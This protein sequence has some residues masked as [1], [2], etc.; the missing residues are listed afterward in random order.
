VSTT[1]PVPDQSQDQFQYVKMPDGSYGKF[2]ANASDELIHSAIQQNFPDAFKPADNRNGFQQY[3]DNAFAPQT[4]Q[5]RSTHGRAMNGVLDFGQAAGQT[6]TAPVAHPWEAI[7]SAFTPDPESAAMASAA[8][9]PGDMSAGIV[10]AL[11]GTYEDAKQNGIP[12]ALGSLGGMFVANDLGARVTGGVIKGGSNA[13]SNL[14]ERAN[15][16]TSPVIPEPLQNASQLAK[17]IRPP[18]GISH[19]LEQDLATNM[20]LVRAFARETGNPMHSQW[21]GATAARGLAQR[22][23]DN[24][25]TNFLEPNATRTVP[26]G[27]IPD[28]Q[29]ASS[30]GTATIRD[31]NKRLS[32]IN[33]MTRPA[34][35]SKTIGA[36]MTAQQRLG[37]QNEAAALRQRLYENLGNATGVAP[38]AIKS[39]RE[40]Y[41]QQFGIADQI[42][43]ARRARLGQIGAG[44]EGSSVPLDKTGLIQ[45][46]FTKARGG[47]QYLADRNFRRYASRFEPTSPTYPQPVAPD[48][49]V[50]A[51]N[52]AAAQQEFLHQNFLD[53]LAKDSAA[54]RSEATTAYRQESKKSF[55]ENM[56]AK[57]RQNANSRGGQ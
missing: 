42:D 56:R 10:H 23:L 7:K 11:R 54:N 44:E 2:A 13:I 45:K 43:A 8:G 9:V 51:R 50:I 46:A 28:Y 20:P 21:E 29:G 48:P 24:F 22:G 4:A 38:D 1:P 35:N 19:G 53:Q 15:G 31:I 52:Q 30:E 25:N 32:D 34:G 40:G 36:D 37:L 41:G 16:Y 17:S 14:S 57:S 5:E 12:H 18:G 33:D 27:D 49:A 39:M 55:G 3:I 26:I 6:M 47:Q